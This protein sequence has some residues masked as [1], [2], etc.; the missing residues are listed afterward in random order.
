MCSHTAHS[1]ENPHQ[2]TGRCLVNNKFDYKIVTQA[3]S[4]D[5]DASANSVFCDSHIVSVKKWTTSMPVKVGALVK[6][7][8][9]LLRHIS[10]KRSIGNVLIIGFPHATSRQDFPAE[11][12]RSLPA[13]F[14]LINKFPQIHQRLSNSPQRDLP[15]G[16][17]SSHLFASSDFGALFFSS[18]HHQPCIIFTCLFTPATNSSHSPPVFYSHRPLPLPSPPTP[19]SFLTPP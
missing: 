10:Q 6:V 9:V 13:L 14:D 15:S 18:L 3:S 1:T 16:L 8:S 5:D 11:T 4:S 19:F 17:D 7:I 2:T 12:P